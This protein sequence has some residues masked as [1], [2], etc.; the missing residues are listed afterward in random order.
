[1]VEQ[2]ITAVHLLQK[3]TI[4]FV[5]QV[6]QSLLITVEDIFDLLYCNVLGLS[7]LPPFLSDLH[8]SMFTLDS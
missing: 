7:Q 4:F 1:M 6:D 2:C 8:A 5:L 3:L